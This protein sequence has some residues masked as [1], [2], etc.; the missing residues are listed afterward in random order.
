MGIDVSTMLLPGPLP[1][2]DELPGVGAGPRA[3]PD[4]TELGVEV[5]VGD[6]ARLA[7]C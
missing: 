4:E 3:T 5:I 7:A 6:G 2:E 1:L